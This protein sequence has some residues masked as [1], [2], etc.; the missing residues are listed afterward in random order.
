MNQTSAEKALR[1][2]RRY[3]RIQTRIAEWKRKVPDLFDL[4]EKAV[5]DGDQVVGS[6]CMC[7]L[8]DAKEAGLIKRGP[9]GES[10]FWHVFED[11]GFCRACRIGFRAFQHQKRRLKARRSA[12]LS[13]IKRLGSKL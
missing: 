8:R 5:Y 4:C 6:G 13:A 11:I 1:L 7:G 2:V 10:N 9:D 3:A 12:V